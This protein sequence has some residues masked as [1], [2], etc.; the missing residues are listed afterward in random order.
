MK[1]F[2]IFFII[3]LFIFGM[4]ACSREKGT[5]ASNTV[6]KG[7]KIAKTE[8]NTNIDSAKKETTD[9]TDITSYM[10]DKSHPVVEITL[11]KGGS[12]YIELYP[13]K[14]PITVD[15]FLKLTKKGFYNGLIFHRVIPGF[16]AQTGDP[17]GT[18]RGGPG[19]TIKDEFNDLK[20][21]R[22][23]VGMAKTSQPNSAGSQFYICFQPQ[24]HLDGRYTV[25]GYVIKGM[26]VVDNIQQGDSIETVVVIKE[27]NKEKTNSKP[28]KEETR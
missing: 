22:G 12:F 13:E 14:A 9:T 27:G 4:I 6:S 5:N 10:V 17:T 7:Q 15:N 19:Y 16:V 18:G 8:T 11:K 3:G 26:D 2:L 1:R 23:A 28:V 25:F 24:P 20:H 21:T